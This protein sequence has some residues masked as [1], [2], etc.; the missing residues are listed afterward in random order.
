MA[1]MFT[2]L[3]ACCPMVSFRFVGR[4]TEGAMLCP[5][6]FGLVDFEIV[7]LLGLDPLFRLFFLGFFGL[8][9][10]SYGLFGNT[11]GALAILHLLG[12]GEFSVGKCAMIIGVILGDALAVVLDIFAALH[13]KL[14]VKIYYSADN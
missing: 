8:V 11:D 14:V 5:R 4:T 13:L 3:P 6:I 9:R 1:R 7:D 10:K 2:L 12:K